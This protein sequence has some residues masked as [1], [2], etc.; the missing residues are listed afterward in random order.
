MADDLILL[1][2]TGIA[3][4]IPLPTQLELG[5]LALNYADGRLFA[6]R[7]SGQVKEIGFFPAAAGH[8][9]GSRR[10]AVHSMPVVHLCLGAAWPTNFG[11]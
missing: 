1:K 3:G 9:F 4:D 2:R 5:E 6:K 7:L 11:W 10:C 8:W